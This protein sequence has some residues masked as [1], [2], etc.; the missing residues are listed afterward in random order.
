MFVKDVL[1]GNHH[2]VALDVEEVEE[3]YVE[4]GNEEY[5]CTNPINSV[6]RFFQACYGNTFI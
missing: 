1:V 2:H 5:L 6:G 3:E 4:A